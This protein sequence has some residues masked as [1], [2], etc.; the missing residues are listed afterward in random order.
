[1]RSARTPDEGS[2]SVLVAGG[3]A[4]LVVF[5]MGVADVARVMLAASRAQTS[6]D[7][8]ALA[9]AQALAFDEREPLPT[10]LAADY[11][12]MNGA[13]LETCTC[14]P[15]AFAATVEVRIPVG[16]LFLFRDDRAVLARA[17]ADVDLPAPA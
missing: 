6:A 1:M 14:D 3:V 7:A 15:G 5:S 2:V 8:A 16:D 17:R 13:V 10:E 12:S 4:A 9:A 11:A